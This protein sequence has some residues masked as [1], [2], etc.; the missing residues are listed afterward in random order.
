MTRGRNKLTHAS[1]RMAYCSSNISMD[2]VPPPQ[3]PGKL[4]QEGGEDTRTRPDLLLTHRTNLIKVGWQRRLGMQALRCSCSPRDVCA[5]PQR[6][7]LGDTAR[8][9]GRLSPQHTTTSCPHLPKQLSQSMP[10][11]SKTPPWPT[12][13]LTRMVLVILTHCS[14]AAFQDLPILPTT[15][16]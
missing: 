2:T 11:N 16:L 3:H 10:G 4:H 6:Q 8:P 9:S 13:H 15:S 14:E 12:V 1:K 5:S 7:N